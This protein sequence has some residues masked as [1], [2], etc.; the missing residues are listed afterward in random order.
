MQLQNQQRFLEKKY[1]YENL[2]ILI[3]EFE[4]KKNIG[5]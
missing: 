1:M 2:E 3:F 4:K 5:R